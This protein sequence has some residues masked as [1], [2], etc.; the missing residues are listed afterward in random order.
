MMEDQVIVYLL[1]VVALGAVVLVVVLDVRG[2]LALIRPE[3]R[4]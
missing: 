3:I 4:Y 1:L 2:V